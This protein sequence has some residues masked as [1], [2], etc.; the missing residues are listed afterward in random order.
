MVSS[1]IQGSSK[2]PETMN[3]LYLGGKKGLTKNVAFDPGKEICR[4]EL[5]RSSKLL[6]LEELACKIGPWLV[7][8]NL[9][10]EIFPN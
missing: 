4:K 1:M 7:S 3:Q 9:A 5:T 8:G 2:D 10:I 6:S